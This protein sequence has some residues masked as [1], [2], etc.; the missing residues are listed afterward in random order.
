MFLKL[1]EYGAPAEVVWDKGTLDALRDESQKW[2]DILGLN[3]SPF[4]IE[5]TGKG[6]HSI[7]AQ[8]VTG[9][10]QIGTI[11]I[12]IQPKFLSSE[13]SSWRRAL[14]KILAIV[15]ENP[16]IGVLSKAGITE[17]DSSLSDL[18]GWILLDSL[19]RGRLEG[20]PR[21]YVETRDSLSVLRGSIDYSKISELILRPHL[22][23]C[24]FD[25]YCEDV[26]INRLF[27]WATYHLST[28]VKSPRLA[29]FLADESVSFTDV[30]HSLPSL[31]ETENINLS[32]QYQHLAPALQVSRILLR[33]QSLQ[34][35]QDN[36]SAPSFLWKSSKIFENFVG[37]LLHQVIDTKEKWY[38]DTTAQLLAF[39]KK[40]I[41]NTF[42]DYRIMSGK[43]TI[44]V[45]DAKY[46]VWG[47]SQKPKTQDVYQ[48]LAA[49]RINGC[50]NVFLVYPSPT[51]YRK[52][53]VT[54]NVAGNGAPAFLRTIFLNLTEMGNIA[55]E[56]TII[57][58]LK[59]DIFNIY[60]ETRIKS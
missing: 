40:N 46:K 37:Y 44:F 33:R 49:G 23:P 21:G 47:K 3:Y 27:R 15:E 42:P 25:V 11:T 34:H 54:W 4:Q 58:A 17:E 48:V 7:R 18:L 14:W 39:N 36:Y 2:K 51:N 6:K 16:E 13:T 22:I 38:I 45:M 5:Y 55:G 35:Q 26:P 59:A 56:E 9:F 60:N 50:D 29:R 28:L 41:I 1:V 31:I 53:P 57:E 8:G 32:I 10:V 30:G 24:V 43:R 52:H 19:R 12:E 20:F